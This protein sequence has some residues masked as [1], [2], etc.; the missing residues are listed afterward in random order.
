MTC[1][2]VFS[3]RNI[4]NFSLAKVFFSQINFYRNIKTKQITSDEE[5]DEEDSVRTEDFSARFL[6]EML[7][8][9]KLSV[10]GSRNQITREIR[11]Q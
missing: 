7:N 6:D 10:A 4:I 1:F 8:P 9:T 11:L 5:G 3:Y 2:R